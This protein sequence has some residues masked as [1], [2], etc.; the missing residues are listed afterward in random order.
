MNK[1]LKNKLVLST[2]AAL[3][4]MAA[5]QSAQAQSIGVGASVGAA[6][7]TFA[8]GAGITFGIYNPLAATAALGSS[9]A[10]IT[11]TVGAVPTVSVSNGGS[12]LVNRRMTDGTNFLNYSVLTPTTNLTTGVCPAAGAGTPWPAGFI[13]TAAPSITARVYNVCAQLPAGQSQPTGTYAD[14]IT[15]GITF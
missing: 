11:C 3:A 12:F 15:V 10:T 4:V 5:S 1:L 2:V 6:S 9:T 14:N 13:L 7:C 8:T